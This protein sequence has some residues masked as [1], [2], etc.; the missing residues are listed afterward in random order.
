MEEFRCISCKKLLF[1][2]KFIGTVQIMCNRCKKIVEIECQLQ[3]HQ[4]N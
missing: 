1:K 4:S 2:G 3:E